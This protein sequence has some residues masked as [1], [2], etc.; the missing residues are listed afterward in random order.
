MI[1]GT[2]SCPD[3]KTFC[4]KVDLKNYDTF[5]ILSAGRFFDN[6]LQVAKK[7]KSIKK[8]FFFVRTKIDHDIQDQQ[9]DYNTKTEESIL[10]E[11]R[12]DCQ[13]NLSSL[14]A[15]KKDAFLISNHHEDKWDFPCLTKAIL[16]AL[17]PHQKESLI[18]SLT[19][20]SKDVMKLKVKAL[21]SNHHRK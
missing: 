8:W 1:A 18:L 10:S 11:I 12:N 17:R 4:E 2:P 3:L 14:A 5:L 21:R 16:D 13:E 7:V 6:N 20:N 9:F 19:I 15:S